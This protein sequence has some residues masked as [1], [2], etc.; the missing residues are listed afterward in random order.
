[1]I[2][3]NTIDHSSQLLQAYI[4]KEIL[5]GWHLLSEIFTSGPQINQTKEAAAIIFFQAKNDFMNSMVRWSRLM[6]LDVL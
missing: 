5:L 3:S 4:W 6:G 2:S 1:M